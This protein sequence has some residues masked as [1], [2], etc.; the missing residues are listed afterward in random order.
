[1]IASHPWKTNAPSLPNHT[2]RTLHAIP[3]CILCRITQ[4]MV[5]G[6]DRG[7]GVFW[8]DLSLVVEEVGVDAAPRTNP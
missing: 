8:S 3:I 6:L 2:A 7:G 1:M 5:S 4:Y